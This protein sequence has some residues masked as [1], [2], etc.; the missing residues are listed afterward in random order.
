MHFGRFKVSSDF[1]KGQLPTEWTEEL[2]KTLTEAYFDQ[3]E[4]DKKF[5]DVYGEIYEKEFVVIV[6]YI[7]HEDQMCS[8]ISVFIS[9]DIVDDS[10]RYKEVLKSLVDLS[11]EIFDDIFA[12]EKWHDYNSNWTCNKYKGCEF[13]YKITRENV[14][15]TLQ[16]EE[17]LGRNGEI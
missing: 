17:F 13:H 16:A 11:G 8:P 2:T 5:F 14:S 15:L 10:K 1:T 3:S 12:T 4:K 9:H 6:S 7:H